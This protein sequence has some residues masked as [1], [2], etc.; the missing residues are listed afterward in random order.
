ME[1]IYEGGNLAP[2]EIGANQYV[3]S[4]NI[5]IGQQSLSTK[6]NSGKNQDN[7]KMKCRN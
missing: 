2:T 1:S 6:R 7:L 3:L 5:G 4:A